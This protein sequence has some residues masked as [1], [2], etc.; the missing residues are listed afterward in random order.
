MINFFNVCKNGWEKKTTN[1]KRD[2]SYLNQHK[3]RSCE[4]PLPAMFWNEM[5][6]KRQKYWINCWKVFHL[7]K[8]GVKKMN[9]WSDLGKKFQTEFFCIYWG[10][11]TKFQCFAFCSDMVTS[12]Y[13][14]ACQVRLVITMHDIN[15][16]IRSQPHQTDSVILKGFKSFLF[17]LEANARIKLR[18]KI[19]T[20]K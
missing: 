8:K 9:F 13:A 15:E 11:K 1:T 18:C 10:I 12:K 6:Y 7:T 14:M 4:E 3:V 2:K 17:M 5:E 16:A 19:P 20:S